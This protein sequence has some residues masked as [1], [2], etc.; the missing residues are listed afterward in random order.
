MSNVNLCE[1]LRQS[2]CVSECVFR[3][4]RVVEVEERQPIDDGAWDLLAVVED[5][6]V[7]ACCGYE[8]RRVLPILVVLGYL[9][10]S[11]E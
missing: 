2:L 6:V 3:F 5:K 1:M 4:G 10:L 8:A 11:H 7:V 9:L